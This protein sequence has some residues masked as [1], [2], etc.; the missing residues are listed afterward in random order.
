MSANIL[1]VPLTLL[2]IITGGVIF[3]SQ[4]HVETVSTV[5]VQQMPVGKY[6][7]FTRENPDNKYDTTI[8][9]KTSNGKQ[10]VVQVDGTVGDVTG[11]SAGQI[12]RFR[13]T[14]QACKNTSFKLFYKGSSAEIILSQLGSIDRTCPLYGTLNDGQILT[15]ITE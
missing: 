10:G 3:Y 12:W 6:F 4:T 8:Y 14:D 15:Q 9:V 2:A 1:T 7:A 13:S 11:P 5:D